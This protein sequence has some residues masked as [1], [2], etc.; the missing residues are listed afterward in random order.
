MYGATGSGDYPSE[1][2]RSGSSQ[3]RTSQSRGPQQLMPKPTKVTERAALAA[4]INELA[5]LDAEIAALKLKQKRADELKAVLRAYAD[6]F[7][8]AQGLLID[9]PGA[10]YVAN[11]G[12]KENKRTLDVAGVFKTLGR[13]LFLEN[14]SFPLGKFDALVPAS[15]QAALVT[16]ER[17][18]ARS[19]SILA[20]A[21][22]RKAAA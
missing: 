15:E 17:S 18:G 16:E 12:P 19:V 9:V 1:G 4:A 21:V 11:L 13:G 5:K 6:H 14:C 3:T 8:A 22:P 10:D 20:R 7:E 2:R